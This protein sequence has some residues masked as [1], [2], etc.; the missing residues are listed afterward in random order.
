MRG[1]LP[2]DT[3]FRPDPIVERLQTESKDGSCYCGK[4]YIERKSRREE[5]IFR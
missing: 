2:G 3:V 5:K 1:D 4:T